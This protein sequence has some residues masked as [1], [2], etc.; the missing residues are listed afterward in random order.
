MSVPLR[1]ENLGCFTHQCCDSSNGDIL[2][3]KDHSSNPS[4]CSQTIL[5]DKTYLLHHG[6]DYDLIFGNALVCL[7]PPT[8][9]PNYNL[10]Q[11]VDNNVVI[12]GKPFD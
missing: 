7:G 11:N 10:S 2:V 5:S 9:S 4:L 12:V 8:I 6:K 3:C 1:E